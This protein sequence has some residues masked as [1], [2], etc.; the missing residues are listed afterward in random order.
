MDTARLVK[1]SL[2]VVNSLELIWKSESY[3]PALCPPV[4]VEITA[5]TLWIKQLVYKE[6]KQNSSTSRKQ[7][8]TKRLILFLKIV[9]ILYKT[10][11]IWYSTLSTNTHSCQYRAVQTQAALSVGSQWRIMPLIISLLNPPLLPVQPPTQ[12][13][14]MHY[15]QD[16]IISHTLILR[17]QWKLYQRRS[18]KTYSEHFESISVSLV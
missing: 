16:S 9:H 8:E 15:F 6:N 14:P 17:W 10:G 4:I 13:S 7:G 5:P 2:A 1:Q 11:L 12:I 3:W 18:S